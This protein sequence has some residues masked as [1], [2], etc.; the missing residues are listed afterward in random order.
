MQM[1]ESVCCA[2]LSLEIVKDRHQKPIYVCSC[3]VAYNFI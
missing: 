2:Q 3:C 1:D